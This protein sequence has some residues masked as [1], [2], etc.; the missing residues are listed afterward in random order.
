[1]SKKY[2]YTLSG[3]DCANCARKIQDSLNKKD[4]YKNVIVNF[5]T[6]KLT[7]ETNLT[8][9]KEE[10]TKIVK[11]IEPD[12]EILD[13][14]INNE[15]KINRLNL[16]RLAI[17]IL[18]GISTLI[19]N[20]NDTLEMIILIFSYLVL[21]PRT[22]IKA[23]KILIRNRS[24]DENM[25]ITISVIG[26]FLIGDG[27]E[28]FMVISL[29]EIGKTLEEMAVNKS[30]KSVKELMDIKPT[31]A[32]LKKG[33]AIEIKN[34]EEIKID[35]IIVIK[36]GEK[37][38]LDGIV[39][40]GE[41]NL[42]T[43]ALTGESK[44]RFVK[45]KD[46]VLS[47]TINLTNLIEV[48]V[49]KIYQ[50]STVSR[51]LD[52]VENATNRKAKTENFVSRAAKVYTPI[53]IILAILTWVL[54]P[55]F[56]NITYE[57]S[58]YRA[59]SFLVISCPCAIA[60]SVPLSY[61][62]GIGLA[63]RKGILVKG[64]DYLDN[65]RKIT[66]IIFDKTG[67]LTTGSFNVSNIISL[68]SDYKESEILKIC[69]YGEAYS[70]HPIAKSV[71]EFYGKDIQN[72]PIK[73]YKEIP[74]KGIS[75]ELDGKKVVIGNSL[76][77]DKEKGTIIYIEIDKQIIGKIII[78]DEI[79]KSSYKTIEELKKMN[80]K[81]LLF[82]GD[83]KKVAMTVSKE[84]GIDNYKYG[85]LPDDKFNELDKILKTKNKDEMV[86][87]VGDGINDAP[88][89]T[90]ADIGISMGQLGSS[91]AIEASDVVLMTDEVDKVLT[92]IDVSQQT[93]RIIKQNLIFSIGVKFLFIILNLF[94]KTTMAWAV[95][96]DV[97][98]TVL[99]ILNSI[100]I[101]KK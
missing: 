28:G 10:V 29:Y 74:G 21:L 46:E 20:M 3:L 33:N 39:I 1:M 61:F 83:N 67:T 99:A 77:D 89:L 12:I 100:R 13:S 52:L 44:S 80:I 81:P 56:T 8:N 9:H 30:K 43:S 70:N 23:I 72:N 51:I 27:F 57:E 16:L 65:L 82:T 4:N 69:A 17:G 47:G 53:I 34:P 35:D 92:A 55:I 79:K 95:F 26:A 60:I 36:V 2:T 91:S 18:L 58:V 96:A 63:S 54:F 97:G 24:L 31:Y 32:N 11:S 71:L 50:D 37:I 101:L 75:Y 68:S 66:T 25:L 62:S 38:P 6:S 59:L 88:V 45:E 98:V 76:L 14:G 86:A 84:L 73:N 7:F 40:K 5:S 42:D 19:F 85:M 49:T 90:L 41:T 48:K 78:K 15:F 94:G 64:S 87:F 22:L 93:A